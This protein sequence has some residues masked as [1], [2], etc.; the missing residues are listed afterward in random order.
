MANLNNIPDNDLRDFLAA[1]GGGDFRD[2]VD[3]KLRNTVAN[4]VAQ[5]K[6]F[7]MV[8]GWILIFLI[9]IGLHT[10]LSTASESI[11][12]IA[13]VVMLL[14]VFFWTANH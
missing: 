11:P 2:M 12:A 6:L 10:A 13:L 5:V 7:F 9:P 4:N 14:I 8:I 1:N 3:A